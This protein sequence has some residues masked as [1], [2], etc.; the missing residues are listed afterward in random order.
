MGAVT[1]FHQQE[2]LQ[3]HHTLNVMSITH[4]KQKKIFEGLGGDYL[5][6]K[7]NTICHKNEYPHSN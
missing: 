2:A 7:M 3:P 4:L 6:G 1:A 5:C